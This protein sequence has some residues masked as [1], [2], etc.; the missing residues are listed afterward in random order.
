MKAF[1]WSHLGM[2]GEHSKGRNSK[3]SQKIK[4]N[5]INLC[6]NYPHMPI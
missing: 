4:N 6:L 5:P 2:L 1:T 3:N